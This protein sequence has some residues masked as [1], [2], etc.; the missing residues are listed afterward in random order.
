MLAQDAL[1][2]C[3]L[4]RVPVS[5]HHADTHVH[6]RAY[7]GSPVGMQTQ[8]QHG[9]LCMQWKQAFMC[10]PMFAYKARNVS[11]NILLHVCT[12]VALVLFKE[13]IY[14]PI[15]V[16]PMH[17]YVTFISSHSKILYMLAHEWIASC[18]RTHLSMCTHTQKTYAEFGIHLQATKSSSQC[19]LLCL[20]VR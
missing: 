14:F 7:R 3:T 9:L 5:V 16:A 17:I 20:C 1:T 18:D 19:L 8:S 12:Y 6:R 13:R 4:R 11:T 15:Q 10:T 2:Q